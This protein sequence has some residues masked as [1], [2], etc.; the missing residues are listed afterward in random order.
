MFRLDI[1]LL[2]NESASDAILALAYFFD[3]PKGGNTSLV[4]HGDLVGYSTDAV[5]IVRNDDQSSAVL[6]S[7]THQQLVDLG[8]R[9]AIQTTA[10][11]IG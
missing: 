8:R 11:L 10:W 2:R 6:V 9:D 5:N 3:R 1:D 4:K 7:T